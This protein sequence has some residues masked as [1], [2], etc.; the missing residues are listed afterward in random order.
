MRLENL[1]CIAVVVTDVWKSAYLIGHKG[2]TVE[3]EDADGVA[4]NFWQTE[5]DAGGTNLDEVMYRAGP[6][7]GMTGLVVW[8]GAAV[9]VH[10]DAADFYGE[11]RKANIDDLLV[12]GLVDPSTEEA[13]NG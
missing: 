10:E 4:W 1:S 12:F 3:S 11:W 5:I 8:E 13:P 6:P 2:G 7:K 9:P